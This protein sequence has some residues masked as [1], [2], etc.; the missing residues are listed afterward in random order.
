MERLLICSAPFIEA[1][2]A[3]GII[4]LCFMF[5]VWE[6]FQCFGNKYLFRLLVK[7]NIV[8]IEKS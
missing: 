3:F 6:T 7:G 1:V 4:I 5:L 8:M 2:M